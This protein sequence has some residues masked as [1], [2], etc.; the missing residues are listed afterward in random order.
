MS[1]FF[2]KLFRQPQLG[3]A[4]LLPSE[5]GY[6]LHSRFMVDRLAGSP[7]AVFPESFLSPRAELAPFHGTIGMT[8]DGLGH[9]A[10]ALESAIGALF[11]SLDTRLPDLELELD[12]RLSLPWLLQERPQE[13]RVCVVLDFVNPNVTRSRWEAAAALGVKV[14]VLS[15]GSWWGTDGNH[16]YDGLDHLREGFLSVDLT[17]DA[18]LWQRIVDSIKTYP[19]RIN[20]I[21]TPTDTYLVGVARAAQALG[22]FTNGP[23]PNSIS[24]NKSLT[25]QLLDPLSTE[26]FSVRSIRELESR[27]ASPEP[28]GFPVVCKPSIGRGS[29]GVFKADSEDALR[30]AVAKSL[31]ASGLHPSG[32]LVEPYVNGPEVDVNLVLRDGRLLYA[33]VVDDF[34]SP[35]ELVSQSA[36]GELFI[37]TQAVAPSKLPRHEQDAVIANM[38]EVVHLQ[39]FHTG[40]FHCEARIRNSRMKYVLAPGAHIPDL[41]DCEEKEARMDEPTAVFLHEVNARI[42]GTMS[43]AASLVAR[44]IDFWALQVL[45]AVGDWE[46]YDA[47]AQ[48]FFLDDQCMKHVVLTNAVFFVSLPLVQHTFPGVPLGQLNRQFVDGENDPMHELGR[49]HPEIMRY[50]VRHNTIVKSSQAYGR[51]QDEWLWGAFVV[52]CSPTSR[53]DVLDVAHQFSTAYEAIVAAQDRAVCQART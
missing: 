27:L 15:S 23:E 53:K 14:V 40:I 49:Q 19:H 47:L 21:F 46:R 7:L 32:V 3:A 52:L 25:R 4:F 30:H 28:V 26:C 39:G 38:M 20:G 44:G 8:S 16:G 22:L 13:R 37:E 10:G 48:P 17:P 1:A 45:A 29:E 43:S 12:Q 5:G 34:P 31:E 35:A 36:T 42:P 41:Q 6:V 2:A 51:G 9:L 11:F 50:V 24:S 18:Q 33:E